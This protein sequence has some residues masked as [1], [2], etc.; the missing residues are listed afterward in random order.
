MTDRA[1]IRAA[2]GA[3]SGL[4]YL[5]FEISN[6]HIEAL[7]ADTGLSAGKGYFVVRAAP[8]GRAAASVVGE[9]FAYFPPPLVGKV[10]TRAWE[11][12]APEVVIESSRHHIGAMA[13]ERWGSRPEAAE[14]VGLIEG[15]VTSVDL[16]GR[17]LAA[18][19]RALDWPTR[20]VASRLFWLA[21]IVREYRG[22]GHVLAHQADG[23][24]AL[25]GYLLAKA[26]AGGNPEAIAAS[27][28]WRD[29]ELGDAMASLAATGLVV[30]GAITESGREAVERVEALTDDLTRIFDGIRPDLAR[31]T[32]LAE[33]LRDG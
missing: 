2:C 17:T 14:L 18:A 12:V 6:P 23:R 21:T 3:L 30:D 1:D 13:R 31:V 33:S 5:Q 10:V 32:E 16:S 26:A 11:H 8:L 24:S 9:A 19:W 20:P 29:P 15:P 27:R 4:A 7:Y 28:S 25:E 22:D